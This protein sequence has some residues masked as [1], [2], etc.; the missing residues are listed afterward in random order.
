MHG[1]FLSTCQSRGEKV[2]LTVSLFSSDVILDA[3]FPWLHSIFLMKAVF[4]SSLLNSACPQLFLLG[5]L[6]SLPLKLLWELPLKFTLSVLVSATVS[7]WLLCL[8]SQDFMWCLK[9][10]LASPDWCKHLKKCNISH[11]HTH[12]HSENWGKI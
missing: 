4:F 2:S 3:D 5:T 11:M 10:C 1:I 12:K 7:I 9:I 8:K 6:C